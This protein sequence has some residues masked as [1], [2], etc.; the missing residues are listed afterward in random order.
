MT[1]NVSYGIVPILKLD[2]G[3]YEY[4]LLKNHGG[5]WGFPK[6]H[7]E[8]GETPKQSAIREA[9]EETGII[10]TESMLH[11]G[12]VQYSYEQPIGGVLQTKTI[13]LYPV[14]LEK[15]EVGMQEEEIAEYRWVSIEQAAALINL[16]GATV[17]LNTLAMQ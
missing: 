15:A 9:Q 5:F 7:P 8:A 3:T 1:R 16:P 11:H 10:L 2:N 12:S 13:V 17:M 6:G 14:R 4:L